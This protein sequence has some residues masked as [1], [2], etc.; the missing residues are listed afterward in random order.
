[1]GIFGIIDRLK[2]DFG[3]LMKDD[4]KLNIVGFCKAEYI[5]WKGGVK[6]AYNDSFERLFI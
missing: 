1:M 5:T 4:M 3:A 6:L 2:G